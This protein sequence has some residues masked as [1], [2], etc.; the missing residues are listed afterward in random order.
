MTVCGTMVAHKGHY[1]SNVFLVFIAFTNFL[2]VFTLLWYFV[3]EGV[4]RNH[5]FVSNT[6]SHSNLWTIFLLSFVVFFYRL[7]N[8][9]TRDFFWRLMLVA[10]CLV[11]IVMEQP[12]P[13]G[14]PLPLWQCL[15]H[16]LNHGITL[17]GFLTTWYL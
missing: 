6:N 13:P 10:Q 11:V 2:G 5:D 8:L 7:W 14:L 17:W 3:G 12:S 16:A 15:Q 4:L 9:P 1:L